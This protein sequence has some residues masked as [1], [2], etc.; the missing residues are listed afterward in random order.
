MKEYSLQSSASLREAQKSAE[1]FLRAAGIEDA[2]SDVRLLIEKATG[3]SGS[4]YYMSRE[5]MMKERERTLFCSMINKRADRIPL[6]H[7]TK[8]AWFYGR[9]FFTDGS[10]L[11][12]RS[13]TEILVEE[14][15]RR[16]KNGDRVLELCTGSGCIAVSISKEKNITV[17][18]SDI[19][20]EALETAKRNAEANG[21]DCVFVKSDMFENISGVYDI[22]IANPPYI[23]TGDIKTLQK[24]V[25]DHDPL[26]ALD[27]GADGLDFYRV[28]AKQS[29]RFLADGGAVCLETGFDQ[30]EQVSA[31]LAENGF[32]SVKTVKDLN[33]LPRV[34]CAELRK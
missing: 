27:G 3:L 33:G 19:S 23:K 25:R 11:I 7:I 29:G 34:V 1:D 21:A 8:E 18:A 2:K 31:L 4:R 22:I 16:I 20:A 12:P 28:I 30:T 15:L 17:T 24:E 10:V 13:D 6:Q 26:I 9:R 14:A 5:E 32:C